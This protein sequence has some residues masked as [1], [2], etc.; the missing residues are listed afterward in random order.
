MLD[1]PKNREG[2]VMNPAEQAKLF[3]KV[4]RKFRRNSER[5][6]SGYVH[7]VVDEGLHCRPDKD[8]WTN[9][10]IDK[11]AAG[12]MQGFTDA[13]GTDAL[14][15]SWYPGTRIRFRWWWGHR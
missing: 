11:Y 4:R 6:A 8:Y 9:S 2:I 5:W 14:K 15:E 12:Y 7:G 1:S 10:G 13:L 3:K